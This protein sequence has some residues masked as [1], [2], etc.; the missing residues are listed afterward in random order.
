ML[1]DAPFAPPKEI[2]AEER[3]LNEQLYQQARPTIVDLVSALQ[4]A[5]EPHDLFALHRRLL[6]EFAARQRATSET[7][8][9]AKAS[10]TAEIADLAT[11][12]PKPL[13]AIR[14]LQARLDLVERQER[15]A[16]A[17][18][19][20]LRVVADGIAWKALG[21]DRAAI[22]LVGRGRRVGHLSSGIGLQAELEAIGHLWEEQ[23]IFAIHNDVTNCLRHGDLIAIKW[24][25]PG[26]PVYVNL[27]EVKASETAR[28]NRQMRRLDE[29][30]TLLQRGEDPSAP[31]DLPTRILRVTGRYRTFLA[32]VRDL[33]AGAKRRRFAWAQPH[34]ALTVAAI[35]FG[36]A[37]ERREWVEHEVARMKERVRWEDPGG[38]FVWTWTHRRLRDR[39]NTPP[40]FAP[41]S[42]YPFP[43]EDVADLTMGFVDV[44]VRLDASILEAAFRSAGYSAKIERP[45]QSQT[46]FLT[47]YKERTGVRVPTLLREQMVNELMTPASLVRSA[48]AMVQLRNAGAFT[49]SDRVMIVFEHEAQ[50]WS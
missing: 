49:D 17:L 12:Q 23:G 42:I 37:R 11:K 2:A 31:S 9:S 38:A 48:D 45:P 14:E 24:G 41:L 16:A 34:P 25:R 40:A 39:D 30:M 10:I 47:A 18:Q 27:T 26:D 4:R 43:A 3:L 13:D 22:A 15:V 1:S 19:H 7:L 50:T 46:L 5:R 20:A 35:A 36:V 29:I 6:I 32:T 8:P 33:I 28:M 44:L 21:Y